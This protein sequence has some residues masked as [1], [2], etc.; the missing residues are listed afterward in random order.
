MLTNATAPRLMTVDE[1]ADRLRV[2]R[3]TAYRLIRE[4]E[5]PAFRFGAHCHFRIR[6]SD[7][8]QWLEDRRTAL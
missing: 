1:V 6:E 2:N 8:E 5:L 7:L 3:A 4:Q